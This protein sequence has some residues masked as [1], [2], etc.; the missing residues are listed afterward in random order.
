MNL[1]LGKSAHGVGE[2]GLD[3]EEFVKARLGE[4]LQESEK[5]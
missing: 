5:E 3:K 1:I 4:V 2:D